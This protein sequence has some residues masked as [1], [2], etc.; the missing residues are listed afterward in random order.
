MA[1]VG[2]RF[3]V[4]VHGVCVWR[5]S[6]QSSPEDNIQVKHVCFNKTKQKRDPEAC[7][8]LKTNK[9]APQQSFDFI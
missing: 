4:R 8:L 9:S 3:A 2:E 6:S 1:S 7:G 5:N